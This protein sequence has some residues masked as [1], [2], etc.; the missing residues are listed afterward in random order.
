MSEP[1]VLSAA[2]KCYYKNKANEYN[3]PVCGKIV[4]KTNLKRHNNS[5]FHK[6]ALMSQKET[7]ITTTT[8]T[9]IYR[10]NIEESTTITQ[11][12]TPKEEE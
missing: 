9:K 1:K 8:T 6:F 2:M 11:E 10:G 3:C 12:N 4:N 5:V 7:I